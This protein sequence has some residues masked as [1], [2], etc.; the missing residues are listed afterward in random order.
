VRLLAAWAALRR[1]MPFNPDTYNFAELASRLADDAAALS[2]AQ[3]EAVAAAAPAF[4]WPVYRSMPLLHAVCRQAVHR[5]LAGALPLPVAQRTLS[6]A[7]RGVA[8]MHPRL[9]HDL[10]AAT[11][12]WMRDAPVVVQPAA[13][14]AAAAEPASDECNNALPCHTPSLSPLAGSS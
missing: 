13:R 2:G 4:H 3:L 10:Q 6:A 12:E 5:S 8:G 11:C 9:A 1:R 14:S 7:V